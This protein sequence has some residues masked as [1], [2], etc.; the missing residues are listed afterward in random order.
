MCL[1]VNLYIHILYVNIFQ[2]V[3]NVLSKINITISTGWK[4]Y[5][6]S[7]ENKLNDISN[8]GCKSRKTKLLLDLKKIFFNKTFEV[9]VGFRCDFDHKFY[10]PKWLN[11]IWITNFMWANIHQEEVSLINDRINFSFVVAI[12]LQKIIIN[13]Y[14]HAVTSI[15]NELSWLTQHVKSNWV[16]KKTYC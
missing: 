6:Q 10:K 2:G 16:F 13:D 12:V 1:Y 9:K 5:N 14:L 8:K 11:L 15:W 4:I 3:G 7:L